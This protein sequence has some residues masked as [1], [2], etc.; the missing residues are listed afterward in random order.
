M[1]TFWLRLLASSG[2]VLLTSMP[3]HARALG[4]AARPVVAEAQGGV[5]AP[6]SVDASSRVTVQ[7]VLLVPTGAVDP[8]S[9]EVDMLAR[10]F[11]WSQ[12]RYQEMLGD[13]HTFEITGRPV[14]YRARHDLAWYRQRPEGAAPDLVAELF[15]HFK[16][17]RTTCASVYVILVVNLADKFPNGGGRPIN[18]G[19]GTGGGVVVLSTF[20]MEKMP[21]F[22]STLQHELGHA[23]GLPHVD[24]YGYS[25]ESN[26]SIMT[27]NK[28]HHS[29]G[30]NPSPTPATLIP[31]DRRGLAMN[32]RVF[33]GL[34]FDPARDVPG[35]TSCPRR[36]SS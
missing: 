20:A 17:D 18:G 7:P 21:N 29:N 6:S 9:N 2:L 23:F 34:R 28:A 33:P 13:G 25:M 1:T 3:V 12:K 36:S 22:Q 16:V 14:V 32:Q 30:F 24:A 15:R 11:E 4:A 5:R 31:E 10:H 19:Y 35:A 8:S 27:Y 26:P